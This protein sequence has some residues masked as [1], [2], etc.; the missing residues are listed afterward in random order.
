M[1]VRALLFGGWSD[2]GSRGGLICLE[3]YGSKRRF[4][5]FL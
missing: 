2:I 3:P 1:G 5:K 4:D